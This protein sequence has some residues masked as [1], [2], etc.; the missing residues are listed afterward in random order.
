MATLLSGREAPTVRSAGPAVESS[1][2]S[3][4]QTL[5]GGGGRGGAAG[6]GTG[7]RKGGGA[8][9]KQFG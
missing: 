4:G 8:E 1:R 2:L 5:G 7:G 3:V 9:R 6:G